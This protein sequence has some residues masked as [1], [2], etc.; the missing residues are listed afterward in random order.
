M[1][2][3]ISIIT[4]L[5]LLFLTGILFIP[6]RLVVNTRSN[7]YYLNLPGY[8]RI[9]VLLGLSKKPSIKFR[10]FFFTFKIEPFESKKDKFKKTG[11]APKF[12]KNRRDKSTG[13]RV[14]FVRSCLRQI[15][16]KKLVADIDTGD[17]PLNAQL[18]PVA[19]RIN[20][21]NVNLN[22]N[23]TNQNNI[24]LVTYTQIYRFIK[25]GIRFILSN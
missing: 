11:K 14:T 12:N 1:I 9:D 24:E 10:L 5:L 2:T 3:T 6:L 8:L 15:K 16:I 21:K 17:F 13:A 7:Q 23:F 18:I 20:N 22:I 4:V 19:Q 25:P